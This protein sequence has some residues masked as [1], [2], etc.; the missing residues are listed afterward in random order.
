MQD[1][2]GEFRQE[3]KTM[4]GILKELQQEIQWIKGI[5]GSISGPKMEEIKFILALWKL[6][7]IW[8]AERFMGKKSLFSGTGTVSP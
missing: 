4:K 3:L 8:N 5:V 2:S 7:C 1:H 6:D